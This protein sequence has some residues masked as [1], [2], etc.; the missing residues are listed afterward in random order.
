MAAADDMSLN[1][2]GYRQGMHEIAASIL[3][4]VQDDALD[5]GESSKVLGEDGI[6][7]T[8]F[9]ADHIEHDSFALF[10]YAYGHS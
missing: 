10:G 4:V 1:S 6:I 2:V 5:L 7:R 9:D 3:W 8:I